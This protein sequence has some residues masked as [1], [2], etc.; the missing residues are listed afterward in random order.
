MGTVGARA[1]AIPRAVWTAGLAGFAILAFAGN[2]LLTRAA[3]GDGRIGAE[4][5]AGIRLIAGAAMLAVIALP[6]GAVVV[7]RRADLPGIA[8][9]VVY[10]AAFT[11]AYLD[12]GAATGALILFGMVQFTMTAVTTIRGT[13]PGRREMAGLAVALAGFGWLLAPGLVAPPMA[14]ALLMGLAGAAWGVYTLLGRGA[15]DPLAQT[16][17]YFVG[18]APLGL[19]LLALASA[20][21]AGALELPGVRG[22]AL[23]ILSG[24][25][26]SAIGYAVWYT[27]L[28]RLSVTVAGISQLLVPAIA[29][30]GG[31]LWLGEPLSARVV[32]ATVLI[33]AGIGLGLRRGPGQGRAPGPPP[34]GS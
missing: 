22:V 34:R 21:S 20:G 2:S 30:A 19:V 15:A 8:A 31:A 32:G 3:L 7:P 10:A 13:P 25:V 14:A 17:R 1:P 33:L 24:A 29:A 23:A 28:P 9:L 5:F 16:A 18:A 26:T 6:R 12:L 11:Y 27:V 4:A